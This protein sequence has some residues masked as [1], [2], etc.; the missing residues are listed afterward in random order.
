[1]ELPHSNIISYHVTSPFFII[2]FTGPRSLNSF[3]KDDYLYLGQLLHLADKDDSVY[4]T[5]LQSCGTFFSSGAN[6][7]GIAKQAKNSNDPELSKWLKNFVATN[8]YVTDSFARHSK[9]LIACL[10]GPAI[11]MSA[12]IVGL[13]DIVYANTEKVYLRFPFASLG[14]ITEGGTS[15]TLPKKLGNNIAYQKLMFNE[16]FTHADLKDKVINKT[17]YI[18]DTEEFNKTILNELNE[19]IKTLYLPSCLKMKK[20]LQSN[21]KDEIVKLNSLEVNDALQFWIDGEPIRRFDQLENRN[22][23]VKL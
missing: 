20:M 11:G 2:K 17:Y 16:I 22:R 18:E 8:L 15:I 23:K 6:F 14:L 4:F 1:M 5:I 12:A 7:Q 9:V 19:K 3:T 13:C 10:N 21:L